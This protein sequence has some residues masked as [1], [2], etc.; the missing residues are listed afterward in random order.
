[1]TNAEHD[2]KILNNRIRRYQSDLKST[3]DALQKLTAKYEQLRH[4]K[5]EVREIGEKRVTEACNELDETLQILDKVVT[6]CKEVSE[7]PDTHDETQDLLKRISS[8]I[9]ILK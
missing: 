3:Q 9:P 5:N 1:M 4:L 8:V 6:I 2:L 7:D